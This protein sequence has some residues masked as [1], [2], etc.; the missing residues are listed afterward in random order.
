MGPLQNAKGW[1]ILDYRVLQ[2]K[3]MTTIIYFRSE[4]NCTLKLT[5][6]QRDRLKPLSTKKPIEELTNKM[7]TE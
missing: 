6:N 3:R 5:E 2:S 7:M 1:E 4:L